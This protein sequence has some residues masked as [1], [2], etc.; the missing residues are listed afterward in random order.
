MVDDSR[1]RIKRGPGAN[2]DTMV[3]RVDFPLEAL[4]T[5]P[6]RGGFNLV[7]ID[8][9]AAPVYAA[10]IPPEAFQV[11]GPVYRYR[12]TGDV[13]EAPG[14]SRLHIKIQTRRDRVRAGRRAAPAHP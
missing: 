13:V 11:R 4:S 5:T 1:L 10:I 9:Q 7:V 14:L 2:D 12:D 8:D 3:L 6:D